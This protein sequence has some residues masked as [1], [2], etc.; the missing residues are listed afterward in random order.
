MRFYNILLLFFMV[1]IFCGDKTVSKDYADGRTSVIFIFLS[2]Y[3]CGYF[4][5]GFPTG[6]LFVTVISIFLTQYLLQR[7][8]VSKHICTSRIITCVT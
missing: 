4:S 2:L 5:D 8:K 7:F 3:W 6:K 1:S